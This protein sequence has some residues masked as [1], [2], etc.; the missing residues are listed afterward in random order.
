[1]E[2]NKTLIEK[3]LDQERSV[4]FLKSLYRWADQHVLNLDNLIQVAVIA[5][6]LFIT[7]V[8]GKENSCEACRAQAL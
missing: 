2:E 4:E 1:M 8:L 7:F 6:G 5:T 3:V